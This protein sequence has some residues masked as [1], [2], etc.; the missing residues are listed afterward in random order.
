V[1]QNVRGGVIWTLSTSQTKIY[2]KAKFLYG[3]RKRGDEAEL[4][5]KKLLNTEGAKTAEELEVKIDDYDMTIKIFEAL[6]YERGKKGYPLRKKRTSY[7]LAD[8]H[9]NWIPFRSF[10]PTGDRSSKS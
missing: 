7:N 4:T 5:V 10:L 8:V 2:R 1:R 9:L 3:V 6:G